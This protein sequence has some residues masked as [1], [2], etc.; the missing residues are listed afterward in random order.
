MI[1]PGHPAS[2]RPDA[3]QVD[4]TPAT[5]PSLGTVL[6]L[7]R[8]NT[9]RKGGRERSGV[10]DMGGGGHA[11]MPLGMLG[12]FPLNLKRR[13]ESSRKLEM[14]KGSSSVY[15]RSV[16]DEAEV[17]GGASVEV[18]AARDKGVLRQRPG[19]AWPGQCP[20]GHDW[21]QARK[22]SFGRVGGWVEGVRAV[23]ASRSGANA[24]DASGWES[25]GARRCTRAGVRLGV[26]ERAQ[27]CAY[28]RVT[29]CG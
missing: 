25:R 7:P 14:G 23:P 29:V 5:R 12:T 2:K 16:G 4:F 13:T 28:V 26:R 18:G 21:A 19:K 15:R 3:H 1:C 20:E 6:G 10:R 24:V 17:P 27:T 8:V 9:V 11:V 22:L